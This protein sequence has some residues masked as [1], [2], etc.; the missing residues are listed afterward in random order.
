MVGQQRDPLAF[1]AKFT[2]S[3]RTAVWLIEFC[4]SK[5]GWN[6]RRRWWQCFWFRV[7]HFWYYNQEN[8]N[9]VF[10]QLGSQNLCEIDVFERG[11]VEDRAR[12][13]STFSFFFYWCLY[14]S[15]RFRVIIH[16]VIFK[17]FTKTFRIL[18]N[19]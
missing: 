6:H 8:T 2:P 16:I 12:V 10:L 13:K 3:H 18:G 15:R 11:G 14:I 1:S 19:V 17:N 9:E 5:I 4:R 7:L